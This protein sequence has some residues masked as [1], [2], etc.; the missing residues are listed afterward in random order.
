MRYTAYLRNQALEEG[1]GAF[2]L[3]HVGQNAE[4]T[5][6][7]IEVAVLDARLDDIEWCRDDERG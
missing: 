5:F 7:V 6:G 4:A 1:T 2:V 3:R